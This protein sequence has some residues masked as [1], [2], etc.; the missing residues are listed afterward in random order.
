MIYAIAL[1]ILIGLLLGLKYWDD[2]L[3]NKYVAFITMMLFWPYYYLAWGK[4]L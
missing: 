1:Y 3:I 4:R 2:T